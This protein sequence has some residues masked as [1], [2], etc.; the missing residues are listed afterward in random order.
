MYKIKDTNV[1]ELKAIEIQNQEEILARTKRKLDPVEAFEVIKKESDDFSKSS[2]KAQEADE[3]LYRLLNRDVKGA[4][5]PTSSKKESSKKELSVEEIQIQER[6]RAR[7]LTILKIK[8]NLGL[9][10]KSA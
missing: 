3:L 10:T 5:T 6:E 9:D 4:L 1:K 8:L 7:K 2:V